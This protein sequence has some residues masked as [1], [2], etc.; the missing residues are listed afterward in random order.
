MNNVYIRFPGFKR[1]TLTLSYDDGMRQD[2]R[3]VDIMKKHGLKG[4]FNINS[5]SFSSEFNGTETKGRMTAEE[6]LELYIP[7]GMEVAVHGYKHLSLAAVD[8]AVANNDVCTD[9]K[10]LES[11]FGRIIKGMAYANGSYNDTAVQ[12]LKNN[13]INYSR[14]TVSTEGFK[15][16]SDWLRLPATCHHNNPRL[17]ELARKFAEEGDHPYYWANAPI[18]FY[19]WGHS[20]EFD[21]N[22]NWSVI[23]EFAEYM[24]NREDIWYATNGEIYDYL[25]AASRLEFSTDASMVYNPTC[26]DIYINYLGNKQIVPAGQTVKL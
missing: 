4:T 6:A 21:N 12:I 22:D 18:M 16:P 2:K 23:E 9:R 3:L 13:G 5:G 25:Q 11:L 20:F 19:L 17:M 10:T 24:G 8:E 1:K 15:I 7:A 26:T 14:T